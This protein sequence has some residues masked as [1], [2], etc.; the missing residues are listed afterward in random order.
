MSAVPA[1]ESPFLLP[2]G[3]PELSAAQRLRLEEDYERYREVLPAD[4]R[5][6]CLD[7]HGVD[8]AGSYAGRPLPH[9]F[10]KASGQLSLNVR[11]VR[12]DAEAG[13]AFVVLKTVI[14]EDAAGEQRM[15]EWAVRETRMR[16]DRIHGADGTPGWTITWKGRGW[17]ESFESYCRFL[18]EALDAAAETGMVIAPSVKYHLPAADEGTFAEGEYHHTTR[19]LLSV[20]RSRRQDPMPLEKDFSPTLAGDDRSRE[21]AQI[22]TWL[23]RVPE[24]IRAAAGDAPLSLGVK[25][26][27]AQADLNFQVEMFRALCDETPRPPDFVVYA[28]RLFDPH[29]EFEG[30]VGVAY[31]GPDLSRRNLQALDLL[32]AAAASGT[33]RRP[34][35]A[36]SGTGDILTGRMAVEYGL[37]GASSCQMHTLFQL[38]DTEFDATTRNKSAAVL[39]RLLLHP[40]TGVVAWLLHLSHRAG[41]RVDWLDLPTVDPAQR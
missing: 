30:K 16:V 17:H 6:H 7:R 31:G 15:R 22:Q 36:L 13:L 10:G 18:E 19:R 3:P 40:E 23:R 39:H 25:L 37:R 14:A 27:N 35:P 41:R 33:L 21:Q 4:L 29:R 32:R 28:N 12:R 26:M 11:Q 24:L 2:A 5:A 1:R 8:I 20:W 38:P 34:L 9:P